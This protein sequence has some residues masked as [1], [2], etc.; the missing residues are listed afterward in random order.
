MP[1]RSSSRP[2]R[3]AVALA[4]LLFGFLGA[5][6][7]ARAQDEATHR[8]GGHFHAGFGGELNTEVDLFD[9][10][11]DPAVGIAGRYEAL[12]HEYVVIGG[13]MQLSFWR[14]DLADDRSTFIDFDLLLKGRYPVEVSSR[15]LELYAMLPFG[16]TVSILDKDFENVDR[17]AAG[18]NLGFFL[19]AQLSVTEAVGIFA[20]IGFTHHGISHDVDFGGDLEAGVTQGALN[21]GA[22]VHL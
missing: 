21:L 6:D 11:L 22:L 7:A 20:E 13:M 16:L 9:S 4:A 12:V 18:W 10:D 17:G 15:T 2:H 19:G 5:P 3:Y 8:V 1:S 14:P